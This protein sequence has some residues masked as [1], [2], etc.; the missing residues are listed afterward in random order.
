M[1]DNLEGHSEA[2]KNIQSKK[3]LR[4]IL[5]VALS[6]EETARD[7]YRDLVPKVSKNIRYLVEELAEEEQQHYDLFAELLAQPDIEQELEQR[8][9]TPHE[10][11]KFSDYVH[12]PSLG[13]SPDD[14]SILQYALGRED[15]AMKQYRQLAEGTEP[16]KIHDLF[17]FLAN[18][19]TQHKRELEAIY[20][21]LITSGGPG[22]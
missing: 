21:E 18:E 12:L 4:E 16:G 17:E 3:T 2:Y 5:E 14:Q 19:E 7:F 8:V 15:S 9:Q 13:E 20:Y 6:F 1:N 22:K 10:D 11:H